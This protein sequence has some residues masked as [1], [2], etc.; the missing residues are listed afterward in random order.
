MTALDVALAEFQ[1]HFPGE[2]DGV[3][4]APGRVNLIGEHTDYNGGLVLPIAL[5]QR[6]YA[7]VRR[8]QDTILTLV[9]AGMP[10]CPPISLASIVA[11]HPAGWERYPAGVLWAMAEAGYPVSGLDVAFASDVPVGSGLSSSAAIEAAVAVA[12]PDLFDCGLSAD[13]SGRAELATLCQRAENHIACAPTGGM[14]QAAVLRSREGYALNLDCADG[15]IRHVP[16]R[17]RDKGLALLVIDTRVEHSHATGEYG[18]RRADCEEACDRLGVAHLAELSTNDLP[19]AMARVKSP[20]LAQRVRHVLTENDRVRLA[21][22]AMEANDFV[23][24]GRLFVDSHASLRDDFEVSCPQL[25]LAVVTA[26]E[27]GALGARMTGGGFGGSA[28]ALV[29]EQALPATRE[30]LLTAFEH[31]SYAAP[32]FLVAEAA[33]P[34]RRTVVPCC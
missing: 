19:A 3:W 9:S 15:S 32:K 4:E 17:I 25:D 10:Y 26:L 16:F 11:G 31:H 13:E 8:R 5:P 20:R 18:Q 27:A 34:A 12:A 23:E 2:P 1:A 21:V 33:A 30:A 7:A 28:I 29:Y 24:L 6:T 22:A 14:D